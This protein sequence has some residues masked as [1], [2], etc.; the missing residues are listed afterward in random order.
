MTLKKGKNKKLPPVQETA[1]LASLPQI[2]R[3]L[4]P[5]KTANIEAVLSSLSKVKRSGKG[6]IAL[7]PSHN[8]KHH[9]LSISEG[10]NGRILLHCFTGCSF[11]E[12]ANALGIAESEF[13]AKE[14]GGIW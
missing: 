6:W 3:Y 8:D 14:E 12:V 4:Q 11:K 13:F 9:S 1:S 7:C 10:A 5:N 2:N